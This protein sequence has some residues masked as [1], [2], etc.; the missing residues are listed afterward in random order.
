MRCPR[1]EGLL[2]AMDSKTIEKDG[3]QYRIIKLYCLKNGCPANNGEP[4]YVDEIEVN[5]NGTD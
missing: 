5:N 3:K 1:C 2:R 4:V